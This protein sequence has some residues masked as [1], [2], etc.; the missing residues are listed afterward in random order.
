MSY[1]DSR[2]MS[3]AGV[4]AGA[5]VGAAAGAVAVWVMDRVDWFAYDHVPEE[6][7]QQTLAARPKGI[8]PAHVMVEKM[9]GTTGTGTSQP[10]L[11]GI[12][13]HYLL[14]VA[15]GAVYGALHEKMPGLSMGRGSMFGLGLFLMQDEGLSGRPQEYPWQAHARGLV[16]HVVYGVVTDTVVRMF[17]KALR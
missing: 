5:A 8:D 17:K 2:A 1:D 12:A 10:H 11:A 9:A 6:A 7:K 15:P 3:I 13:A 16:A 4:L 14:G